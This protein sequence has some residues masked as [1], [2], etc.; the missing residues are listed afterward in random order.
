IRGINRETRTFDNRREQVV[1]N[2]GPKGDTVQR[3]TGKSFSQSPIREVVQNEPLPQR[4][5]QE[6]A[7]PWRKQSRVIQEQ[8]R[9]G[10]T[11][12]EQTRDRTGREQPRTYQ[13]Q[14]STQTPAESD[15]QRR[16]ERSA[17]PPA[18]QT[19]PAPTTREEKSS[20]PS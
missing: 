14:P 11:R 3:A 8:P 13:Q 1:V 15:K 12:D 5:I 18:K 17:Q 10:N 16:E 4:V 9:Q 20:T 6:R 19:Q 7:E 2:T